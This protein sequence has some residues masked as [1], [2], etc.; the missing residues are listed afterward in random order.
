MLELQLPARHDWA[1]QEK[2][3]GKLVMEPFEPGLA[4]TVGDAHGQGQPGLEGLDDQLAVVLFL[5]SPVVTRGKLKLQ[6]GNALE[7]IRS[8]GNRG[9]RAPRQKLYQK[10]DVTLVE[11]WGCVSSRAPQCWG[12]LRSSCGSPGRSS[13]P[14]LPWTRA[15]GWWRSLPTRASSR[16]PRR[17]WA[18]ESSGVA[19]AS[20]R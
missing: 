13:P 15:P 3:Y 10:F 4:L 18:P 16:S 17:S 8:F 6:H 12:P 11:S 7:T 14:P 2:N 19:W 20:S 9:A 5:D 1:V